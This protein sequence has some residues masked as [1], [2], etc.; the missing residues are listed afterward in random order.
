MITV[1]GGRSAVARLL[2]LAQY[3]AISGGT[4]GITMATQIDKLG[5]Q[6]LQFGDPLLHMVQVTI[7]QFV[8]GVTAGI[9]LNS[10]LQQG[11][12]LMVCHI[13]RATTTDKGESIQ[14]VFIII[15][16]IIACVA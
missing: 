7:D 1:V 9:G 15:T 12:D 8:D 5:H 6:G 16:V 4:N 14:M 3:A 11:A 13:Q 2:Q 10:G